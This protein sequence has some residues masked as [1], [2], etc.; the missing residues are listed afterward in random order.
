MRFAR[1][2]RKA[3]SLATLLV[4]LASS[5][6]VASGASALP[7]AP[8]ARDCCHEQSSPCSDCC[9][10]P[11]PSRGGHQ[12]EEPGQPHQPV[13]VACLPEACQCS[14]NVPA[15]PE[16]VNERKLAERFPSVSPLLSVASTVP[17]LFDGRIALPLATHHDRL[18]R[19]LYLLTTSLLR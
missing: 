15:A 7:C 17:V 3:S 9:T 6:A 19:P 5:L 14:L 1:L 2:Q 8:A 13:G 4:V 12:G 16:R 10:T 11:E 18:K